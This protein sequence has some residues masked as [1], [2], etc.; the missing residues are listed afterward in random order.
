MILDLW[1][2]DIELS[3]I[4]ELSGGQKQRVAIARTLLME[5]DIIL[6]DEPTSALDKEMKDSVLELINELVDEDMTLIVVSHEDEFINK[7]SDR[8]FS[9]N[10]HTLLEKKNG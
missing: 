5:P 4:L 1:M 9:F 7:V 10:K 8:I 3:I 2:V 6:L